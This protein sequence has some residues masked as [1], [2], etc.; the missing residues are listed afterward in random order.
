MDAAIFPFELDSAPPIDPD[1]YINPRLE[2][3]ESL[4]TNAFSIQRKPEIDKLPAFN[5]SKFL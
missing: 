4:V 3:N 5:K 1:P 2:A